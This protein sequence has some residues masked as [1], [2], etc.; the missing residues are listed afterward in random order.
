MTGKAE[1]YDEEEAIEAARERSA[2][3][4]LREVLRREHDEYLKGRPRDLA[5]EKWGPEIEAEILNHLYGFRD[6]ADAGSR[7]SEDDKDVKD[8]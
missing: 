4:H 8:A 6:S 3:P 1:P 7:A 5:L 2:V